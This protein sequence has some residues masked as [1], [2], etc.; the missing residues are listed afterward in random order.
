MS[1]WPCAFLWQRSVSAEGQHGF[2]DTALLLG[3]VCV[4]LF[5]QGRQFSTRSGLKLRVCRKNT[6]DNE[7]GEF[8]DDE[9]YENVEDDNVGEEHEDDQHNDDEDER[10]HG[11]E[12]ESDDDGEDESQQDDRSEEGGDSDEDDMDEYDEEE[13][14]DSMTGANRTT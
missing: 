11:N 2:P 8:D 10:H 13:E 4:I 12:S 14:C 3:A 1:S 6:W 7:G 5:D 9:G